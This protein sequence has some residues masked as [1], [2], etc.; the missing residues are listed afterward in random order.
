[1]QQIRQASFLI[2]QGGKLGSTK[3]RPASRGPRNS[4]SSSRKSSWTTPPR[5]GLGLPRRGALP[6]LLLPLGSQPRWASPHPAVAPRGQFGDSGLFLAFLRW[7]WCTSGPPYILADPLGFFTRRRGEGAH[8]VGS[9]CRGR[10][11]AWEL[12]EGR[13]T[14]RGPAAE[15]G[16]TV[17]C[18]GF[19]LAAQGA[20]LHN[21]HA[22]PARGRR[23]GRRGGGERG[24]G[25]PAA[26]TAAPRPCPP[27]TRDGSHRA[28][29]P[30]TRPPF[31]LPFYSGSYAS[32]PTINLSSQHLF[33]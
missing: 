14:R 25:G 10:A 12:P 26:G 11:L 20:S 9:A 15:A 13:V 21:S 5:R 19:L 33:L 28:R 6:Y 17:P 29:P 32:C 1:M 8:V 7:T 18:G 4:S 24:D 27:A 31:F 2:S 16:Q 3:R 23:T 30:W 22:V